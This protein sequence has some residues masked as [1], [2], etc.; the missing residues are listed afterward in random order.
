MYWLGVEQRQT[1]TQAKDEQD[2]CDHMASL[3][4]TEVTLV[5]GFMLRYR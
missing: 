4:H 5:S 1:I 3:D 2:K